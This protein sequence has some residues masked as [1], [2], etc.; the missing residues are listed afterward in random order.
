VKDSQTPAPVCF[1]MYASYKF[2]YYCIYHCSQASRMVL[3]LSDTRL[4]VQP[5]F[6]KSKIADDLR[7]NEKWS[8]KE[9][10]GGI[11][12]CLPEC[13]NNSRRKTQV[14][15]I[16]PKE[17]ALREKCIELIE[18]ESFSLTSHRVCSAQF[19]GGRKNYMN[20][21]ATVHADCAFQLLV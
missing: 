14:N 7:G 1:A 3:S 12:C 8:S 18:S 10:R 20:N 21:V 4:Q 17:P 15:Y 6:T 16:F 2:I 9:R 13:F 11:T 19:E 5:R